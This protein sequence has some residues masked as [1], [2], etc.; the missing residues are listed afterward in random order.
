MKSEFDKEM[1]W[2]LRG[3]TKAARRGE[4]SPTH[5]ANDGGRGNGHEMSQGTGAASSQHL[6]ADELSAYAENALPP[7]TRSRY[8]AHL[9]D[10]DQCRKIATGI[11]LNAGVAAA[12]EQSH[13]AAATTA[14][15]PVSS[16]WLKWLA[17]VFSPRVLRYAVPA[18]AVLVVGVVAFVALRQQPGDMLVAQREEK[19]QE[20]PSGS[21]T[22][23]D[24]VAPQQPVETTNA[25]PAG[26]TPQAAPATNSNTTTTTTTGEGTLAGNDPAQ[27]SKSSANAEVVVTAP[28]LR[29]PLNERL[30]IEGA[31]ANTMSE[32][33]TDKADLAAKEASRDMQDRATGAVAANQP[34]PPAP[35][36]VTVEESEVDDTVSVTSARGGVN[37]N[38]RKSRD[39]DESASLSRAGS[40]ASRAGG[41][42][43]NEDS[44]QSEY[45]S[46]AQRSQA[47]QRQS[48]PRRAEEKRPQ[49]AADG[50]PEADTR[51]VG[52]R[53]FR[54]QDGAWVDTA[55]RPAQATVS[56]RRGS[57][58]FRVLVADEPELRRIADQL[59]GEIFV[60]WRGRAYRI[61]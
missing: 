36:S 47:R 56:I 57:E 32:M 15:P 14:T 35:K 24:A 60:V 23:T 21:T 11:A 6:D 26:D 45:S 20:T 29:E 25:T 34:P 13:A 46:P 53:R 58:Q 2:L 52:G 12:L 10:C 39:R 48:P 27:P 17:S 49:I 50:E 18:L 44:Y 16:S 3:H 55:Y 5:D 30:R 9:A 28:D 19:N 37:D 1:E 54:R 41:G 59:G 8:M 51:N 7:A 42:G 61:R 38:L 22:G 43:K 40:G 31:G 33:K 4:A